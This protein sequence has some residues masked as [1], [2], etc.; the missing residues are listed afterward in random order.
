MWVLTEM[1]YKALETEF[2]GLM[3][4]A[5]IYKGGATVKTYSGKKTKT[6]KDHLSEV[7]SIG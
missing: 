4:T 5:H 3:L 6:D 1:N 2:I 7:L